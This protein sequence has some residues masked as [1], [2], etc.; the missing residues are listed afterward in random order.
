MD[1]LPLALVPAVGRL[2]QL[3]HD[4]LATVTL[5]ILAVYYLT[6]GNGLDLFLS[7][8]IFGLEHVYFLTRLVNT[9]FVIAITCLATLSGFC[10]QLV[11][12]DQDDIDWIEPAKPLLISARTTHSRLFPKKHSF[13]YSYL[14][15]GVPV[16]YSGSIN[17]MLSIDD[18]ATTWPPKTWYSVDAK[19]YLERGHADLSLRDK[20]DRYLESQNVAPR[21]Y[22]YAYLV[23]AARF[24]GHHFNPVSFWYLYS[25][26]RVLSALVLE[27]NNT[28]DERRPYLVLRD[29]VSEAQQMNATPATCSVTAPSR[30]QG[31]WPKDFHVSPFNSRKGSYSVLANDPLG[32]DMKGFRGISV[33][34]KLNSSKGHSKLVARLFSQGEAM[35]PSSMHLRQRL[36]FVARWFWVGFATFPRI[37]KEAVVLF[38]Q[39]RLHVWYRPEP[40]KESL[41]RHAD[42]TEQTLESV[43]RKYLEFLVKH[44]TRPL[45][46]KYVSSGIT[47]KSGET[48]V[49]TMAKE[50]PKQVQ[51][52]ELRILTPVFYSRFVHY[53][54]D[55][56][57]IFSELVDSGT[58]WVDNASLLPHVFLKKASP[59]LQASSLKD[60]ISFRTMQHLR[61]RPDT[62]PR[63]STSADGP[64]LSCDER[65]IDIREFRISSM[66]A[67]VLG[68]GD[69]KLTS[70]YRRAVLR[71]FVADRFF[72]GSVV[73]AKA[74]EFFWRAGVACTLAWLLQ[75]VG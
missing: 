31:S 13:S 3:L 9:S 70:T 8:F 42:D 68:Q 49:S 53:A 37:V 1:G 44:S 71:L 23:T 33:T 24:L 28:F 34:I 7:L 64:S 14:V 6:F 46:V 18:G 69:D 38:F 10:Y 30:V 17:G 65:P 73:L 45:A 55:F 50:R 12:R 52:L 56:E 66:D 62:I 22:P 19:D 26:Q 61:R 21:D 40:L 11:S 29:F 48:Y 2:D 36:L 74:I 51:H 43:F 20:L 57:A 5:S 75:R 35:D 72:K 39:R 67:F 63:V 25:P 27:V 15:A 4:P 59:P 32:P 54:H 41:G 60:Y 47:N 58:V 16:G